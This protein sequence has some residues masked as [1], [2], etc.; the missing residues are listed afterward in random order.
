MPKKSKKN[1]N[2]RRMNPT[3]SLARLQVAADTLSNSKVTRAEERWQNPSSSSGVSRSTPKQWKRASTLDR[4][5]HAKR[6][7]QP[8]SPTGDDHSG[9]EDKGKV[10][11]DAPLTR[12]DIPKIVEAVMSKF[13]NGGAS[14]S[15]EEDE[16]GDE[17]LHLGKYVLKG[18]A[19]FA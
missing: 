4:S 9:S 16:G 14:E 17:N 7:R 13:P 19:P 8:E 10:F 2:S 11:D 12:A 1:A 3:K 5:T 18:A 6:W 15:E